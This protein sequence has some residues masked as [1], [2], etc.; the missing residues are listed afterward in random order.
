MSILDM[1]DEE[2]LEEK[3]PE[4]PEEDDEDNEYLKD[5][6]KAIALISKVIPYKSR[7]LA[8][9]SKHQKMDSLLDGKLLGSLKYV[10]LDQEAHMQME[11]SG[12]VQK[13]NE[14]RKYNVL[15]NKAIVGL[16]GKF[17]AGKSG[18]INSLLHVENLLPEDQNPTTSLATYIVKG[19][20]RKIMVYSEGNNE[21]EIDLEALNALTHNFYNKYKIGFSS[22]INC[23][24]VNE[25][26]MP[27]ED[28]VFLDTPGYS[29]A[30]VFSD[31]KD[32]KDNSDANKALIQLS[33]VDYLIW[34]IDIENGE[35]SISDIEFIKKTN[36]STP[37]LFV[38][39]KADKKDDSE[40]PGI[41]KKVEKTV[42]DNGINSF[43]VTAYSKW[44][45]GE[46][47]K[48]G[49]INAYL[50]MISK[51]KRSRSDFRVQMDKIQK[52]ISSELEQK[53]ESINIEIDNLL[54]VIM[55][56][57]NVFEIKTL[58]DAYGERLEEYRK[59]LGC[60]NL[61]E[62]YCKEFEHLAKQIMEA[63][64]E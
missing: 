55:E 62:N 6:A 11:L 16:G 25:A 24:I 8:Q 18:L 64:N 57:Q 7:N 39:N 49:I 41:I 56:S 15:K 50:E 40:I 38:L 58:V 5:S 2:L 14:E 27:Y 17:S 32:E 3:E 21:S 36:L 34:L 9:T 26:E 43:G 47:G 1:D 23:V 61:F 44:N 42:K 12:L 48:K 60:Q 13:I 10:Q 52:K 20:R 59:I 51:E 4:F 53:R 63:S 45:D 28:I 33:S 30:D 35:I 31:S 22:F 46:W 37:I 29:K 54:E 19:D